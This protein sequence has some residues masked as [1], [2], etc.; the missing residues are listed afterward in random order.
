MVMNGYEY[1][2]DMKMITV[3][4]AS[5][6]SG[7]NTNKGAVI[8]L[9]YDKIDYPKFVSYF[10]S[11]Y[12]ERDINITRKQMVLKQLRERIFHNRSQLAKE[13]SKIA[14]NSNLVSVE[15]WQRVLNNVIYF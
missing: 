13:F 15:D 11:S 3:F 4:S 7:T 14:K 9:E 1:Q 2:H 10:A 8:V 12:N 6:Y 5:N